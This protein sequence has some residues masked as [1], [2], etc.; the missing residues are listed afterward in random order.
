M[1]V[2]GWSML[3]QM[4]VTTKRDPTYENHRKF[5]F[6]AFGRSWQQS[7][8]KSERNVVRQFITAVELKKVLKQIAVEISALSETEAIKSF[9]L[10]QLSC[11]LKSETFKRKFYDA[12]FFYVGSAQTFAIQFRV[13]INWVSIFYLPTP[14][15]S[16]VSLLIGILQLNQWT[17][18][19]P[20]K[21]K[22][23]FTRISAP[24]WFLNSTF[25]WKT[26][27]W[28]LI[29]LWSIL[30]LRKKKVSRQKS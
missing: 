8:G 12:N 27:F 28:F 24:E 30:F 14:R 26:K 29:Q 3:L 17:L 10:F 16:R 6:K 1:L 21:I 5:T 22:L 11:V 2:K 19:L 25:Q 20:I 4:K 15:A 23:N 7:S 13:D 9:L 18:S